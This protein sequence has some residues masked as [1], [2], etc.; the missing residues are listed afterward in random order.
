MPLVV[1]CDQCKETL[2]EGKVIKPPDEII[3]AHN[4]KCPK[5]ERKLT[6]VPIK[7]EVKPAGKRT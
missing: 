1:E 6:F 3:V 4:G 5:C 2:Y 7:V